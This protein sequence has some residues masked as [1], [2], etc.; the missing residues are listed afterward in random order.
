MIPGEIQ[1]LSRIKTLHRHLTIIILYYANRQHRKNVKKH[2]IKAHSK[3][4]QISEQKFSTN[5]TSTV[6]VKY[7]QT[8]IL[9]Y[10]C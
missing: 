1:P 4:Q 6:L 8:F 9:H 7:D 3:K 10:Y 5:Y 2:I